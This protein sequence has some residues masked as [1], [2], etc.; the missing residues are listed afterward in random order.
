[1]TSYGKNFSK[2]LKTMQITTKS[3][4]ISTNIETEFFRALPDAE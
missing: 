4:R 1:M 2:Y 3:S